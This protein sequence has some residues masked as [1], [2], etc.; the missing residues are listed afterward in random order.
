MLAGEWYQ[1]NE[2]DDPELAEMAERR[3]RLSVEVND[4]R[5]E[6]EAVSAA[7][8]ELLGS[9]GE[10]SV[11]RPPFH[12]DYGTHISVGPDVF[13]N[14][15]AVMLDCAPI[16]IG[17]ATQIAS[18][19]QLLTP[20]HPR[21]P[22]RR[23]AGWEAAHPIAIGE[24]VWLG[25]GVIVCGGVTIG[26]DAIVGAGAVVVRDVPAGATVVGNPAR[27]IGPRRGAEA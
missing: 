14:Y 2:P 19:V 21:D 22:A 9:L 17:A 10:R 27:R 25:G 20:D 8:A 11:I 23:R 13:V 16:T 15:G 5:S 7:L 1:A 26:D 18:S 24:N 6:P 3:R 12:C 4:P